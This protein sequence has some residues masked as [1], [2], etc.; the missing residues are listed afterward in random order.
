MP[1]LS[2]NFSPCRIEWR[3]SRVGTAFE[4]LLMLAAV[5]ALCSTRW[6]ADAPMLLIAA[7]GLISLALAAVHVYRQQ[8]VPAL[9]LELLPER[10]LR[11]RTADGALRESAGSL[12]EQWPVAVLGLG[13]DGPTR[14][15]WPDT[16]C[17]SQRR[18]LRRWSD[19]TPDASPL[20]QFWMG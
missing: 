14:V 10:R 19:A 20:T 6:M 13:S 17:D 18:A 12:D 16:L 7:L 11:W 5:A 2:T 3:P 4:A 8:L 9:I 15:F 1:D